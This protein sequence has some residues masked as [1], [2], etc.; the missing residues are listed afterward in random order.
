MAALDPELFY[1]LISLRKREYQS[2]GATLKDLCLTFVC[3]VE[4]KPEYV[5]VNGQAPLSGKVEPLRNGSAKHEVTEDNLDDYVSCM[6]RHL[7]KRWVSSIDKQM[8]A[9]QT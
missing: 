6:V 5:P 4:M 1:R 9:L 8:A 7:V 3:P 2:R